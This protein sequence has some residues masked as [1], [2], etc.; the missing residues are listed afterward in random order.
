MWVRLGMLLRVIGG[1]SYD[2][3]DIT[4]SGYR[5]LRGGNIQQMKVLL[6][7]DDVFLPNQYRDEDKLIREGD[8]LIVASTG[9]IALMEKEGK[10]TAQRISS[11]R[12]RY[13]DQDMIVFGDTI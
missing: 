6:E 11:K 7:D 4:S 2:K 13:K 9:S 1:V 10:V 12:G 8:I 3:K 5:I